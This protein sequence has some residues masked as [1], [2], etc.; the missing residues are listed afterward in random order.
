M[1]GPVTGSTWRD[2]HE[3][4]QVKDVPVAVITMSSGGTL[5][6]QMISAL[7]LVGNDIAEA[8]GDALA[9]GA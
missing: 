8:S 9:A 1:I 2:R 7:G 4:E 6:A 5:P 3:P